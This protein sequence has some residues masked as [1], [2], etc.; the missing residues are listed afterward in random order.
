MKIPEAPGRVEDLDL[1]ERLKA[2]GDGSATWSEEV[3][4]GEDEKRAS[5][6]LHA[7]IC[8]LVTNMLSP[9]LDQINSREM[10]TFTAHDRTHARKVAHVM[11]HILDEERRKRLT[12]PEIALLILSAYIHDVGMAISQQDRDRYLAENSDL[13]LLLEIEED[14]KAAI[15]NLRQQA[16]DSGLAEPA[17]QLLC[18]R[19]VQ[20]EETL[21]MRYVRAGHAK[22][23]RYN[24]VLSWLERIH[25][26]N[27]SEL[28]DVEQCLAFR[29]D[30]F[31][32]DLVSVCVSHGEDADVLVQRDPH[33]PERPRFRRDRPIGGCI[34]DLQMVAGALRLADILD[35]DRERTPVVL[36]H[37]LLPTALASTDDRSVLEW[38]K[39][40]AISCWDI[41]DEA[42]VFRG[43]CDN[44]IVHH[45]IVQFAHTIENE[46]TTTLA[47]FCTSGDEAP[48]VCLPSKVLTD[49]HE[50]GYTYVP[51]RFELDDAR[52]YKLLMGGSIYR[53][54]L[55]AIR[56]LIQ[57]AVDACKLKDAIIQ[58]NDPSIVPAEDGRIKIIYEES[59]KPKL[60]VEDSGTGM[61][62]WIL[63]RYFLKVGRSF[64]S[65]A[66]FNK[67][68]VNLRSRQLDFAPVSEFGIGFLSCFLLGDR[69]VV[70]S[71][72]WEP[73]HGNDTRKRT[74]II[75]GPT[76][77]IR[78]VEEENTGADR[79]RGTRI[80]L[81]LTRGGGRERETSKPPTWESVKGYIQDVCE[82]LPYA[83][84]LVHQT[85][86]AEYEEVVRPKEKTVETPAGWDDLI[87]CI[88]LDDPE[89]G[90]TG[91]LMLFDLS[92]LVEDM[93][94]RRKRGEL[95]EDPGTRL[96]RSSLLRGGFR[97]G[98][99]ERLPE[100]C[101][102]RL[103]LSWQGRK[104]HRLL[105]PNLERS[106]IPRSGEISERVAESIYRYL[107]DHPDSFSNGFLQTWCPHYCIA[108][109]NCPW[110]VDYSA[111]E[112]YQL[113]RPAWIKHLSAF[114]AP[115]LEE[116][117]AGQAEWLPVS[118][119]WLYAD[120][121][122][123]L[124]GLC[125]PWVADLRVADIRRKNGTSRRVVG[126]DCPRPGWKDKLSSVSDHAQLPV[127]DWCFAKLPDDLQEKAVMLGYWSHTPVGG[128]RGG[129]NAAVKDALAPF[130]AEELSLAA[131]TLNDTAYSLRGGSPNVVVEGESRE[132][133]G[134]V[135]EAVGDMVFSDSYSD[136]MWPLSIFLGDKDS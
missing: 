132:I 65:S 62:R 26:E 124:L 120:D 53:N 129:F 48:P 72:M 25:H 77:L 3:A 67:Y 20:A 41:D 42:V 107:L 92:Q 106:S 130:S 98:K 12:P 69:L 104:D 23:E 134:R 63:E 94:E 100:W 84:V 78:L 105:S 10:E 14:I 103:S 11:W 60:I 7:N 96:P 18:R 97:I 21:I 75:D 73:I 115:A 119:Q 90:V 66:E 13:W 55:V 24:E 45:T 56:E 17:R 125:L 5:R 50:V 32:E 6:L 81:Q 39:H 126:V 123:Y 9:L 57:N 36:F 30:S 128:P 35:F 114:Q 33:H 82:A 121:L 38:K 86:D 58:L 71:A 43:K 95:V 64:Y 116:W 101:T 49:I 28:P 40:M 22:Q 91:A 2:Y 8:S 61:D 133:V 31:R 83:L 54:S 87:T 110:L 1:M 37:Y 68:R 59:E 29:G 76:R 34:V 135:F 52:V 118:H 111:M 19:L 4:P 131:R 102:T 127:R 44:H 108:R 79:F 51:Y 122:S 99:V 93:R 113:A 47:A 112:L 89:I 88:P 109:K 74:L 117:E 136:K 16:Q 80:T 85:S 46:I 70:E 15:T 27:P